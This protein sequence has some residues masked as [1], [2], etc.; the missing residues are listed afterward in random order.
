MYKI[1]GKKT[2][3]VNVELTS[4]LDIQFSIVIKQRMLSNDKLL[5]FRI[6]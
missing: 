5:Q 3:F 2:M 1:K 6:V 4:D